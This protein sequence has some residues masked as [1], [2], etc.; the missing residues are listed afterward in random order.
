MGNQGEHA[1]LDGARKQLLVTQ[2]VGRLTVT[3]MV[4][5]LTERELLDGSNR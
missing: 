1:I 5:E 3:A 2:H 4:S